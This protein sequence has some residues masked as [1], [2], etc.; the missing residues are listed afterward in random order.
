[1][2]FSDSDEIL[3]AVSSWC[4]K[5]PVKKPLQY[6]KEY[7]SGKGFCVTTQI[8]PNSLSWPSVNGQIYKTTSRTI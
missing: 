1:M 7:G 2:I 8:I 5:A 4:N 6:S 3:T